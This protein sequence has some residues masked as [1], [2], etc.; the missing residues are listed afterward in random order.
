MR[1]EVIDAHGLVDPGEVSRPGEK[2]GNVKPEVRVNGLFQLV[3][4]PQLVAFAL[5]ERLVFVRHPFRGLVL[6]TAHDARNPATLLH[7]VKAREQHL[8]LPSLV[9]VA[10]RREDDV[11]AV[12]C[13]RLPREKLGHFRVANRVKVIFHD[14]FGQGVLRAGAWGRL[15]SLEFLPN[16]SLLVGRL[17][18]E[19]GLA[20][21]F[22]RPRVFDASVAFMPVSKI[23]ALVTSS[24][25]VSIHIEIAVAFLTLGHASRLSRPTSANH[26]S[27]RTRKEPVRAFRVVVATISEVQADPPATLRRVWLISLRQQR[28]WSWSRDHCRWDGRSR[29]HVFC[30]WQ[31]DFS[32]HQGWLRRWCWPGRWRWPRHLR[33]PWD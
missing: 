14:F 13:M 3:Q 33:R 32:V 7:L 30:N 29:S 19:I 11:Q 8:R 27:L 20:A 2:R 23:N 6:A 1:E 12:V 22:A 18:T 16:P 9:F 4:R 31:L 24:I 10:R 17:A 21:S 26:A 25:G 15:S 5:G 28:R